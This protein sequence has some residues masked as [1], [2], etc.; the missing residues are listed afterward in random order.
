MSTASK[1]DQELYNFTIEK[2]KNHLVRIEKNANKA[3][4][5]KNYLIMKLQNENCKL[6]EKLED[7]KELLENKDGQIKKLELEKEDFKTVT[8]TEVEKFDS[9]YQQKIDE[10]EKEKQELK[11]TIVKQKDII[12]INHEQCLVKT[13]PKLKDNSKNGKLIKKYK[14][15][16]ITLKAKDLELMRKEEEKKNLWLYIEAKVEKFKTKEIEILDLQGDVNKATEKANGDVV[17]G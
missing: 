7:C 14:D 6:N 16:K 13:K 17:N 12:N 2:L 11:L 3:L 8:L 4:M 1:Y 15:L 5:S 9:I 10:L